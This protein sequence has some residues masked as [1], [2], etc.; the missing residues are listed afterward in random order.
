MQE[1]KIYPLKKAAKNY[2]IK[3]PLHLFNWKTK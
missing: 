1:R 3:Q 2:N